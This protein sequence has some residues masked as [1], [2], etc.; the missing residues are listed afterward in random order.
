MTSRELDPIAPRVRPADD[1]ADAKDRPDRPLSP[2]K[3]S[4]E[5]VGLADIFPYYAGFSFDWAC[6]VI[7]EAAAKSTA[8]VLD[9]WNG[10]G[11]T[12]LAAQRLG[13]RGLGVDLNPVANII[14]RL[15]AGVDVESVT[16]ISSP[17][18]EL[19]AGNTAD[20][21]PLGGWF[22]PDTTRRLRQWANHFQC[23][24]PPTRSLGIVAMF[25]VVRELT[26]DFGGSNPTWTKR[27]KNS[28]E[29]ISSDQDELDYLILAE[30]KYI[31]DR[32]MSDRSSQSLSKIVTASACS[33]PIKKDS[34]D[35]IVTSPPYLT[36][37]DYAAAYTRELALL[38]VNTLTNRK[39]RS[40]LMGTTLIRKHRARDL[41]RGQIA[42]DLL[43]SIS[44]HESKASSGY[45]LKQAEQY[46]GDLASGLN[47]ITRV[48]RSGGVMF[49]VV[50]DSYYKDIHVKLADICMEE[51]KVRGWEVLR[52]VP[53]TVQRTLTSLNRSAR[54]YPKGRVSETVMTLCKI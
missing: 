16:F 36:R 48:T 34:I 52:Q 27:A 19:E 13:C 35:I 11:T 10:S 7:E 53:F 51:L 6:S 44:A 3:P 47:E 54:S 8:R 38:G 26:K 41:I 42:E 40:E 29:L 25:R 31:Y 5:K 22:T 15:R 50:Q 32:L 17:K 9:P 46:L 43:S 12:T 45:Y 1:N 28:L 14:A 23:E 24:D 39:L 37:I 2:K 18:K 49:L 21:D 4:V 20:N 33:L 30:Q